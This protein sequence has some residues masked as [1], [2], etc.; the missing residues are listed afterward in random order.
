MICYYPLLACDTVMNNTIVLTIVNCG[1]PST[2]QYGYVYPFTSTL[3]GAELVFSCSNLEQ[4][5][6]LNGTNLTATCSGD[7][8]WSPN[9]RDACISYHHAEC[10]K[11]NSSGMHNC[12]Y[13]IYIDI[14]FTPTTW[15]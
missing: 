10:V 12:V 2:P 5:S 6:P 8:E 7:G 4:E 3:E 14:N 9:P 13:K 11:F 1:P 15:K